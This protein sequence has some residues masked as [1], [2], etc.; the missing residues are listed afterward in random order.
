MKRLVWILAAVW[1]TAFAQVRPVAVTPD[2]P[3][4]CCDGSCAC[5]PECQPA[6]CA[7]LPAPGASNLVAETP[8]REVRRSELAARA[9]PA[10]PAA[11]FYLSLL[12]PPAA[13]PGYPVS[14]GALPIT[15][16]PR[17]KAHCSYLL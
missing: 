14:A 10:A 15:A 12:P 16:V 8:G 4:K 2:T 7:V 6:A 3:D 17:F 11:T 9:L 5:S 13:H 1:C